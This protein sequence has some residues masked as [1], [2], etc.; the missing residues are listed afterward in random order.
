MSQGKK[1]RRWRVAG[2]VAILAVFGAGMFAYGAAT[3]ILKIPPYGLLRG[4]QERL[5]SPDDDLPPLESPLSLANQAHYDSI[6]DFLSRRVEAAQAARESYWERDF[7]SLESY[8]Q[9]IDAYRQAFMALNSVPPECLT[10]QVPELVSSAPVATLGGVEIEEM[11]LA[12]CQGQLN[13]TGYLAL[14]QDLEAPAPLVIAFYGTWGSPA[15]AFGLDEED[16]YH[17]QFALKLAEQGYVVFVPVIMTHKGEN[18]NEFRNQLHHRAL[19][20][21]ERLVGIELGEAISALDYLLTLPEVNSDAVATYGIS[22]GGKMSFYLGALDTRV[23]A[24]VVSQYLD[25]LVRKLTS[26]TYPYAYWRYEESDY[27]YI[28]GLLF[29]FTNVDIASL[30]VPRRLFVEAGSQD[31]RA[32]VVG[33]VVE[34]IR[35][36]YVRLGLPRDWVQMEI[37]EGAHEIF[38]EGSL[39]FLNAWAEAL[40][41]G[42][43]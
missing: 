25:D 23:E 11:V 31:P 28:P 19:P 3:I 34:E 1:G 8:L 33:E 27:A 41:G 40:A 38:L 4:I 9:S 29:Q 13:L 5:T 43:E 26:M 37:G 42:M 16:D 20:L 24:V 7:S 30:I 15:L 6:M 39:D 35:D 2:A 18:T 10:R 12:V 32:E 36:L 14:P 17:H 22:L 21:G